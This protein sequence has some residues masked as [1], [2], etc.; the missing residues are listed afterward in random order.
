M[1]D[2]GAPLILPINYG[3]DGEC[4][5]FRTAEGTKLTAT[6]RSGGCFEIDGHDSESR[7]G[8]SVIVR[9]RLE[10]VTTFAGPV[11]ER[12]AELARP[13]AEGEKAHVVRLVPH[14]ITGRQIRQH[15]DT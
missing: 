2:A 10:E 12:L 3:M 8:W 9:G 6:R 15:P 13:W 14:S 1:H 11:F 5:V 7:T 4:V